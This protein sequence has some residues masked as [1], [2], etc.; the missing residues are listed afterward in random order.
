MLEDA[1][2]LLPTVTA[3]S[4]RRCLACGKA[5]TARRHRYCTMECQ[6]RLLA[7]L[8]R[9]TG[10]LRALGA[11][12]ATFYFTD[13]VIMMDVLLY[14]MELIHSYMLTR[15][16]G[17]KPVEDFRHLSNLLGTLWWDEK[18]RTNKRYL[19]S[20]QVLDQARKRR[21]PMRSIMP[22]VLTIPTVKNRNL[23]WLK[24]D[25]DDL[26]PAGLEMKIKSAYRRQ[27]MKHHPD[28]GGSRET[29]LKIHEAYEKLTQWA[30]QP[31]F[32]QRRG[33]PDKWLYEGARNRWVTPLAP[34]KKRRHRR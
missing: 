31:S 29:F 23:I 2:P 1:R 25:V 30:M 33:F 19:A 34:R 12:Y 17:Q 16:P 28:L 14:G 8:N 20:R 5:L 27:A 7:A 24:L 18:H 15:S 13:G 10:L 6:Q 4:H 26:D 11:R 21:A 3:E 32:I 22:A 9:R